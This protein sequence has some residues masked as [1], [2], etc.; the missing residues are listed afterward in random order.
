MLRTK[1][2]T[3]EHSC[4]RHN[5]HYTYNI[6]GSRILSLIHFE[7]EKFFKCNCLI[8]FIENEKWRGDRR[9]KVIYFKHFSAYPDSGSQE[10]FSGPVGPIWNAGIT[11]KLNSPMR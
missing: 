6:V 9:A 7:K 3:L 1:L 2:L 10:R 8:Y 4:R 11:T 5:Y